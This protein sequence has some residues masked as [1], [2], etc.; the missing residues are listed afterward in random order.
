MHKV[1]KAA[2]IAFAVFV[3]AAARLPEVRDG[4]QLGIKR[5]AGIPTLVQVVH[6]SLRLSLPFVSSINVSDEVVSNVV[7]N[8]QL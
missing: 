7:A 1:A 4:G 8:M 2:A 5:T 3:L 6:S